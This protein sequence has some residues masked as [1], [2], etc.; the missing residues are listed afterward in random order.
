MG[1]FSALF[2][3]NERNLKKVRKIAV[4]IDELEDKY[5]AMAEEELCS[6]SG[7]FKEKLA[8][9][10]TLDDILPDAFAAVREA[11]WRVLGMRHYFIQLIGGI[12][13]HQG[14]IAEM[15]TGE[16][17]TLVE[18]LPAYLNALAG[19]GVHIVTVNEY[20]AKRDA[21]WMG[22][23]F[24][25]LGLSVGVILTQ[26]D[27]EEKRKAYAAD[28][29]YGTNNEFGF[30]YLRD[31][32]AKSKESRV[33]RG[34]A[35]A[36][37]DEV[38]SILIDEARTPLII[39]AA[40]GKTGAMYVQANRFAKTLYKEMDYTVEEK[41]KTVSLTEDG[42][43]KA[44]KYFK[45]QNLSDL[46]NT[47]LNHYIHQ[48]LKANVIMKKDVDY[49]VS[50]GEVLIVDEFTGRV[51][52]GRRYSEGLHQ[53]I[54]AKE[55]VSI[56]DENRTVATIT[57]QNYFRLYHKLSGM[58]GTAKTEE[59]E[60]MNI[61]SLD[62]VCV[63][64][65]L[66]MVRVDEPDRIYTTEKGKIQAI[67]EDIKACYQKQQPVLVGTISVEK[68]EE[69]SK[70]LHR[71]RIPHN[72]LNAKNHK[73]EAEIV[74]QAGRKGMVTIAT[75]MA[76][77][78]T[79]IMLG[80]NAEFMA[81]QKL[82]KDGFSPELIEMA[83]SFIA[84]DDADVIKVRAEYKRHFDAFKEIT[85]KE[86]AEVIECGGLRILGT[87]RHESRRIDNQLRGRSGRQGDKGS[88]VFYISLDDDV[89]RIFGGD[90]LKSV[91]TMLKVD[92]DMPI[93]SGMVS[94]QIERAQR[95]VESR[96]FGIRKTVLNYDDVMN[97]QR[98]LIYAE[99]NKVLDGVDIHEQ[100][101]EMIE[102]VV[103]DIVVNHLAEGEQETDFTAFNRVLEQRLLPNDTQL[104]TAEYMKNKTTPQ[105]ID[106]ITAL[107]KSKYEEKI[108][109]CKEDGFDFSMLE[110]HVL[111]RNVDTKWM[112]HIDAM[113][114]LRKG[115]G[116]R[117]YGQQ[118]PVHAYKKEGF[119][120]FEDM[121][122]RI[123]TDT[124][125]MLMKVS[126]EKKEDGGT[127][128]SVQRGPLKPA[129]RATE[130]VGRNDPCPCGSGKKYKNCCGK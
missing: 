70:F 23:I 5:K 81:K 71:D 88:S 52:V 45:V 116:L 10:E 12:I 94:K 39:S 51:M 104:I 87:E 119:D 57:L 59:E 3:E 8:K 29:T 31:N 102:P 108:A 25:Y 78:G 33:Q 89:A 128:T 67:I 117:A 92:D 64:T 129:V 90:K 112:D 7:V 75:N 105:L 118:N 50:D 61:Y 121:I 58:T 11:S 123:Q 41:E 79:D 42:I 14:R 95:M 77:R 98:E 9:G 16:G 126:I 36:I 68:S 103:R 63:P 80:G 72:V 125:V 56:R 28:I 120:M 40:G 38:D 85:E 114:N 47:E 86:K 20:L 73:Q 46:D 48:A 27:L 99:R 4:Q 26:Q 60:F 22:K 37:V 24:R 43:A 54:E 15:R 49:I 19:N 32:M 115:I 17:K 122:S 101:L 21:E 18:T 74:A 44:E 124:V 91:T 93:V 106:D 109:L 13:L 96:N 82:E 110:R 69:L 55:N 100:I 62:V 107:V 2:N 111:L 6:I 130:K 1:I 113:D 65:N 97:Q 66:P 30:D 34:Y 53:A 35:F 84:S 83:T 127:S 76:G